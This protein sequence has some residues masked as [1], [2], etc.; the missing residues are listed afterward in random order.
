MLMNRCMSS[1]IKREYYPKELY[2]DSVT[3]EVLAILWKT[4][5]LIS[6]SISRFQFYDLGRSNVKLTLKHD[7]SAILKYVWLQMC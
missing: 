3:K 4:M 6:Y 7:F 5:V 2:S 1:R